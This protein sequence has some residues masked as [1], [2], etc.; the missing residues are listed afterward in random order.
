M[1]NSIYYALTDTGKRINFEVTELKDSIM[2]TIP[3]DELTNV[4]KLWALPELGAAKSGDDGY[5]ILPREINFSGDIQTFFTEREDMEFAYRLPIMSCYG[6]KTPERTCLVRIRRNYDYFLEAKIKNGQYSLSVLF[7]FLNEENDETPD[8]DIC[9]ELIML[10]QNAD[11]NDMARLEREIRMSRGEIVALADKCKRASV[12]Y[13]R[14]YPI[15]RIRMGWKPCASEI[16]NQTEENEPDMRVACSFK[17]VREI[18]DEMKNQGIEGVELQLVGWNR[19][20]HD[21]RFPQLFPADPRLGGNDEFS[22]TIEYV[23][24]LGYRISTHTNTIDAYSI[25][26][27]FTYDDVAINRRGEYK[28]GGYYSGGHS[29]HVCLEKQWKNTV[30]DLPRLAAYGENGLHFTDV[31]SIVVPDR[32]YAEKH[33]SDTENGIIYAQ[34]IEEYTNGLFGGFCSEGAMDFAH[35]NLDFALYVCFGDGFG[36]KTIPIA[37][38]LIPFFEL[39]YHGTLLYNPS[40]PTVNYTIKS[41]AERLQLYMRGGKPAMYY[42]SKFVTNGI[43]W[44]GETDLLCDNDEQLRESV[45]A[46][47]K[48]GD[49]YAPHAD[50][51]LVY[52]KRYDILDNG[53]EIATYEDE[54]KMIGNFT[55]DDVIYEGHIIPAMD[56]ITI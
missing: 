18:A 19:S 47:K 6:I 25:A 23:K 11:Y 3:K 28:R 48:A 33:P 22:K 45:A 34:K 52:M 55:N 53:L 27:T 13:A 5:W 35:K 54:T 37:D 39:T 30:R 1:N 46:V 21:G 4:K 36:R 8:N 7:D 38:R 29:Y 41:K 26:D 31:I 51:Q 49:E 20:G 56:F 44:M 9:I 24:A 12:D 2:L 10:P 50:R 43:N 14:K 40:S 16:T 32:C 17:R 15:V 42:Y